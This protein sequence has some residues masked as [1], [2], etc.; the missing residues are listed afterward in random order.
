MISQSLF[1]YETYLL[2]LKQTETLSV[3]LKMTFSDDR[4]DIWSSA[5]SKI[6]DLIRPKNDFFV[7]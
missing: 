2:L 4:N 5:V 3:S 6:F 1:I 7:I